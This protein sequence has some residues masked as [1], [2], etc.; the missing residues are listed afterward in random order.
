MIKILY[1]AALRDV[2]GKDE[3][4]ITLPLP[5]TIGEVMVAL[6]TK[7]PELQERQNHIRV[8]RNTAFAEPSEPVEPHDTIALLPPL[9]GG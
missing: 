5:T 2:V 6:C 1:F 8:A 3:E 9:S 4:Q 7:Y